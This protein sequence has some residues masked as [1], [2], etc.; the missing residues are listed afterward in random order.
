MLLDT[1]VKVRSDNLSK[2]KSENVRK[3]TEPIPA[4]Q[5][6]SYL[7]L[8]SCLGT[9]GCLITGK[10]SIRLCLFTSSRLHN[11][12]SLVASIPAPWP[13]ESLTIRRVEADGQGFAL[14]V[15]EEFVDGKGRV[16]GGTR[17]Q[18]GRKIIIYGLFR[19]SNSGCNMFHIVRF[20][21][22]FLG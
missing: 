5:R 9:K 14:D 17:H 18:W 16:R 2:V 19:G 8:S 15:P 6:R 4:A 12:V 1:V 7:F 3:V 11:Q 13:N 20:L 10:G 22:R 21:V